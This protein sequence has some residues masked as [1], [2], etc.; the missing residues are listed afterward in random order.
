MI[1][2]ARS[3]PS[4]K[5]VDVNDGIFNTHLPG[6]P[7]VNPS[8]VYTAL[9]LQ[10][11]VK[12]FGIMTANTIFVRTAYS[13]SLKSYR[14]VDSLTF[15]HCIGSIPTRLPTPSSNRLLQ[16]V[17]TFQVFHC[18]SSSARASRSTGHSPSICTASTSCTRPGSRRRGLWEMGSTSPSM[19]LW[20]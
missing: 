7:K 4:F 9:L 6:H 16:E 18:E 10:G 13:H 2:G 3:V 1:R 11:L 14:I 17:W 12:S 20:L 19:H 5:Y 8:V 15:I